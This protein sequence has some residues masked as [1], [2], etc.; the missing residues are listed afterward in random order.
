[1][2]KLAAVLLATLTFT[3]CGNT[4]TDIEQMN[5]QTAEARVA[6][7][8]ELATRLK[9]DPNIFSSGDIQMFLSSN[10]IAQALNLLTDFSVQL[11]EAPDVTIKLISAVPELSEGVAAINLNLQAT[12]GGLKVNIK[13]VATLLPQPLQPS[14]IE[15]RMTRKMVNILGLLKK[16]IDVPEF[17]YRKAEPMKFRLVVERLVP[18]VSWSIFSGD[19]KGFAADFAQLKVNQALNRSMP[20]IEIPIDNVIKIDQPEQQRE[21]PLSD[22]AYTAS[23][24][25]PAVS[26]AA[27]FGLKDVIV[28]PRGIHLIG[29]ISNPRS[30]P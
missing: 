24:T 30:F 9:S 5:R 2:K 23:L 3:G 6:A 20:L 14:R 7:A 21:F 1:M 11:P 8:R 10:L 15:M 28:L 16:P 18:Q 27:S 26:W 29:E 12:R 4:R 13:G 19:V 25:T 17:T 22:G